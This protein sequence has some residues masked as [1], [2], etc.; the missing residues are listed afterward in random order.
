[1]LQVIP[2]YFISHDFSSHIL[3]LCMYRI[4]IHILEVW[5][6]IDGEDLAGPMKRLLYCNDEF[7]NVLTWNEFCMDIRGMKR[8][9]EETCQRSLTKF[10]FFLPSW[11]VLAKKFQNQMSFFSFQTQIEWY[12]VLHIVILF[13]F[14][15][16]GRIL[17]MPVFTRIRVSM[18]RTV[19]RPIVGHFV[20]VK[21]LSSLEFIV[22]KVSCLNG[23]LSG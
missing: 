8:N 5:L 23:K 4:Y 1:M 9:G 13:F 21:T 16:S 22:K 11:M 3:L 6:V 19:Y 14:R 2:F 17:S 12:F 10:I 18:A 7:K 20:I 15:V